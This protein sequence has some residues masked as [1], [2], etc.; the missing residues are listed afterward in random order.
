MGAPLCSSL[1]VVF[2]LESAYQDPLDFVNNLR[3]A[4]LMLLRDLS[5]NGLFTTL[6]TEGLPSLKRS[7]FQ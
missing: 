7:T 5:C 1:Q 6:H 2:F 4:G 3:F